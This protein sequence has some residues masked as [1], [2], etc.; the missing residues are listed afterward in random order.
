MAACQQR[1]TPLLPEPETWRPRPADAGLAGDFLRLHLGHLR[2][3]PGSS[4]PPSTATR[5]LPTAP[6]SPNICT[7]VCTRAHTHTHRHTRQASH[8]Q[9]QLSLSRSLCSLDRGSAAPEFGLPTPGLTWSHPF[10]HPGRAAP[11][12]QALRTC[13]LPVPCLFNE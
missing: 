1:H 7:W 6:A 9:T 13:S 8:P 12:G 3:Q 2:R 4:P 5:A 10:S 11:W